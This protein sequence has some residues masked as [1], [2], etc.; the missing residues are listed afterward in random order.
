M[1]RANRPAA[2]CHQQK[3]TAPDISGNSPKMP[4]TSLLLSQT[5]WKNTLPPVPSFLPTIHQPIIIP[6]QN[7][8][9]G[10]TREGFGGEKAAIA[11]ASLP[12]PIN[13]QPTCQP[14]NPTRR[15]LRSAS[16]EPEQKRG[17]I[18]PQKSG[19][20]HSR[21]CGS[22][23][24]RRPTAACPRPPRTRHRHLA[25]RRGCGGRRKRPP[26]PTTVQ[27]SFTGG[28]KRSIALTA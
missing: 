28:Y 21:F 9:P 18:F 3:E 19:K 23:S 20:S 11:A 24:L 5:E 16:G 17:E 12:V 13:R 2:L 4:E 14:G 15:R 22:F 1:P 6:R 10:S 8:A 27:R 25:G 26:P 7:S